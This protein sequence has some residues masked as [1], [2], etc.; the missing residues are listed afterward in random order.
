MSA[1]RDSL[2][3]PTV[4]FARRYATGLS[5]N[6]AVGRRCFSKLH[7]RV[8]MVSFRSARPPKAY[9]KQR[10]TQGCV[11]PTGAKNDP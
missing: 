4:A 7:V 6:A 8:A 5:E 1:I 10:L 11:S 2:E 3:F 9:V